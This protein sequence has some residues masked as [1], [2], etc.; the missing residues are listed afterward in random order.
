MSENAHT[1]SSGHV[2]ADAWFGGGLH[3]GKLYEFGMP[4]GVEARRLLLLFFKHTRSPL[5]WIYN[6]EER[7]VYP[8]AW[9]ALGMDLS[10]IYFVRSGL[11]LKELR[12]VFLATYKAFPV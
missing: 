3:Y 6:D 10:Q 1:L 9:S 4:K 12:P 8:P 5:L 7:F 2:Q 11:P